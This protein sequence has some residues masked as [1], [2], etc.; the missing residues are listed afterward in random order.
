MRAEKPRRLVT[1]ISL[2]EL[3]G[4]SI[5][6]RVL[7]PR[8]AV[9]IGIERNNMPLDSIAQVNKFRILNVAEGA[10]ID[11]GRPRGERCD[12]RPRPLHPVLG[13][14]SVASTVSPFKDN[15]TE[16]GGFRLAAR[17]RRTIA[18]FRAWYDSQ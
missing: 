12:Q 2:V 3:V 10:E 1:R 16:G 18:G 4:N 14:A 6:R 8:G 17:R 7:A 13:N 15:E 11:L 9:C 5:E